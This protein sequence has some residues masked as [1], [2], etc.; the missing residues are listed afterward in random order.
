MYPTV[1]IKEGRESSILNH[2]PWV[3]TGALNKVS[4]KVQHG[5][6]VSVDFGGNIIAT[7]M[8]SRHSMI[9]VRV[10]AFGEVTLDKK[11]IQIRIRRAA[12][13]RQTCGLLSNPDTTA[14]RLIYGQS[15][16]LPGLVVDKYNDVLV[17]QIAT[18]GMEKL[19]QDVIDC[20]I[21]EF[22]PRSI[23][24]RSDIVSRTEEKLPE[25][26]GAI[27]GD[28]VDTVEFVESRR[29]YIADIKAGQKTG[30]YLDQREL[31]NEIQSY[32]AGRKAVDIF[33]Y[34]GAAGISALA[35]GASSVEF[36]DASSQ[37]LDLCKKHTE[38]NGFS[39]DKIETIETDVFQ[40]ISDKKSPE[41]DLILLDP[42][43]LIK[44]RKHIDAG[45]KGYH[46]LNR[47]CLRILKNN[48]IFVTSSCSAYLTEDLFLEM[49]RKAAN[50]AEVELQL[51]KTIHQSPDHPVLLNFPESLYL[52][53]FICRI[54]RK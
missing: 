6:F 37:A 10:M 32:S 24:E 22:E 35:G 25:L 3:F 39:E 40:W 20:L 47:A 30:F 50:Q 2:H 42:P 44:S 21:E 28:D 14:C 34:T 19:R 1:K 52:K 45:K 53:S 36:I 9:A 7:G 8:F 4:D 13:L 38:L 26:K 43:A 27:Y 41:Y 33:S 46:F 48:G 12:K 16:G 51:I 11:W 15:D 49:L 23:F 29:K 5:D 31:R 54:I 17:L 18:A